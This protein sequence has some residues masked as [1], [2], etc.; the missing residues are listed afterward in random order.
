MTAL[1]IMASKRPQAELDMDGEV[2]EP[3]CKRQ[4]PPSPDLHSFPPA[5]L[6]DAEAAGQV[7]GRRSPTPRTALLALLETAPSAFEGTE[8]LTHDENLDV[9]LLLIHHPTSKR[10]AGALDSFVGRAFERRGDAEAER[11]AAMAYFWRVGRELET[12]G[13]DAGR[14]AATARANAVAVYD[15]MVKGWQNKAAAWLGSSIGSVERL[16]VVIDR[17]VRCA[18]ELGGLVTGSE[19]RAPLEQFLAAATVSTSMTGPDAS[20]TWCDLIGASSVVRAEGS[21]DTHAAG[22]QPAEDA[23]GRDAHVLDAEGRDAEIGDV[24]TQDA[25]MQGLETQDGETQSEECREASIQRVDAP[26]PPLAKRFPDPR[27][28]F[29]HHARMVKR[30]VLGDGWKKKGLRRAAK[31]EIDE[32]WGSLP[33]SMQKVWAAMHAALL[34]GDKYLIDEGAADALFIDGHAQTSSTAVHVDAASRPAHSHSL[35][36]SS[37]ASGQVRHRNGTFPFARPW[38]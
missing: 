17:L 10:G 37:E 8:P 36:R 38:Y 24:G 29:A 12:A 31:A 28:L 7:Q 25:G 33:S 4:P 26:Q 32:E 19:L 9:Q 22:F 30:T 14:D 27:S 13:R 15:A 21:S 18:E 3:R 2:D 6:P 23:D 35:G 16:A 1:E 11:P 20:G 34:D 5:V